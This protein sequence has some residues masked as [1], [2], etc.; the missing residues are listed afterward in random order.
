[1]T[2]SA[3]APAFSYLAANIPAAITAVDPGVSFIDSWG[4][5]TERMFVLGRA[6]LDDDAAGSDSTTY[7]LIGGMRLDERF[8]IPGFIQVTMG[9]SD[10]SEARGAAWAIW[11]AFM[12]WLT[13]HLNLGGLLQPGGQGGGYAVISDIQCEQTGSADQAAGGRMCR[14]RFVLSCTNSYIPS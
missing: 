8:D 12:A 4:S 6:N 1:V 11:D 10:A 5:P 14:I 9:G 3:F 13:A 2:G 7:T